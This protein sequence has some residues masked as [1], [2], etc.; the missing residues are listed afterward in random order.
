M[1]IS[2]RGSHG[3]VV[4]IGGADA[5]S[6]EAEVGA[7]VTDDEGVGG[8]AAADGGG[9]EVE[10]QADFEAQAEADGSSVSEGDVVRR[11]AA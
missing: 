1:M 6:D 4:M 5:E 9:D 11:D 7:V 3:G 10:A 8:P 2:N